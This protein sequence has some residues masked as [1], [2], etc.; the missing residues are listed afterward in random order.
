MLKLTCERVPMADSNKSITSETRINDIKKIIAH[1]TDKRNVRLREFTDLINT[2]DH[3]SYSHYCN[4]ITEISVLIT[5]LI[6]KTDDIS[7]SIPL[8][9]FAAS[10]LR[11]SYEQSLIEY[12]Q[13][14]GPVK[15]HLQ[16]FDTIFTT[17]TIDHFNQ[18][19]LLNIWTKYVLSLIHI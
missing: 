13:K 2:P 6:S 9:Q 5:F 16:L 17:D 19:Y 4:Y 15:S 7:I 14:E 10:D 1:F 3:I 8:N 18:N 12:V 11:S